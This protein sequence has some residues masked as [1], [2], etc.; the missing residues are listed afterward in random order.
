MFIAALGTSNLFRIAKVNAVRQT[1]V[2]GAGRQQTVVHSGVTQVA[3]VGDLS[4]F[5][6]DAGARLLE[7]RRAELI[8]LSLSDYIQHKYA[9]GTPESDAFHG[10]LDARIGRMLDLGATVAVTADHGMSDKSAPHGLPQRARFV[11]SARGRCESL[12]GAAFRRR[13]RMLSSCQTVRA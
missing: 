1:D 4:L 7:E 13:S 2:I 3:F 5:V 11:A 10:A 6:M 12:S 9:P 8:Y